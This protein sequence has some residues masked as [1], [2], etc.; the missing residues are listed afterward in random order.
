MKHSPIL[1][2]FAWL[3]RDTFRQSIAHGIFLVLL[4]ISLLSIG[5]CLSVGVSGP[6]D[7]GAWTTKTPTLSRATTP[8]PATPKKLK[9]RA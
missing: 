8:T 3:I 1:Q 6:D 2:T 4:A 5:V 9:T 7:A